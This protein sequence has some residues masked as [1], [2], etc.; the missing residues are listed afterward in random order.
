MRKIL[1][2]TPLYF[3]ERSCLGGGE[4]YPLNLAR[5]IVEA[6][7]G[8][9]CVDVISYDRMPRRWQVQPGLNVR[10]LPAVNYAN[11]LRVLSWELAEVIA[12][13]DLVHIHQAAMRASEAALFVAK[14]QRKPV[15]VTDH[16]SLTSLEGVFPDR[17]ELADRI[18][19]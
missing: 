14:Q 4:R 7:G 2:L 17:L 8:E 1:H 18:V 9:Y 15:C 16:G 12:E 10:L 19:C 11:P 6:S 13:A 3:N 5:G